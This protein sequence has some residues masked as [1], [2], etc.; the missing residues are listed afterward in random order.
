MH[1][2]SARLDLKVGTAEGDEKVEG[3]GPTGTIS[4]EGFRV[5]DNG[6]RVFFTGPA[7]LVLRPEPQAA[8]R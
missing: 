6:A 7:K 3:H 4:A 2:S 8:T 5:L 1:S